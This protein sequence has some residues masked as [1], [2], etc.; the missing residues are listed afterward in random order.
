M[1]GVAVD[2]RAGG[3]SERPGRV[4]EGR[5]AP[6]GGSEA[7][8]ADPPG[9]RPGDVGYIGPDDTGLIGTDPGPF[10]PGE[11]PP[12]PTFVPR[13][14]EG[15]P[16]CFD[17]RPFA[18]G[19]APEFV[20]SAPGAFGPGLWFNEPAA[21]APWF[22]EPADPGRTWA[23]AA[24]F[25]AAAARAFACDRWAASRGDGKS[26]RSRSQAAQRAVPIGLKASHW[27]HAIPIS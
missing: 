17:P 15:P 12:T 3:K 24:A 20:T 26:A 16:G 21:P 25:A 7:G 14:P 22:D 4:T 1:T 27:P 19:L 11:G 6:A 18:A 5:A 13:P 9:R 23:A 8:G 2:G 10:G